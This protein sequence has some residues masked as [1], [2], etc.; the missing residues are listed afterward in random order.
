MGYVWQDDGL[1]RVSDAGEVKLG[2]VRDE[3]EVTEVT[4]MNSY[5]W[6]FR[7]SGPDED[8]NTVW[9][10]NDGDVSSRMPADG[11]ERDDPPPTEGTNPPSGCTGRQPCGRFPGT[12]RHTH[13][14]W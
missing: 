6:V 2:T 9:P 10:V 8:S 3:A 5:T 14:P 11:E 12:F 1:H 13:G 4:R 7:N